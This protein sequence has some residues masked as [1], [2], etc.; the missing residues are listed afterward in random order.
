MHAC[1]LLCVCV[2]PIY[3]TNTH[4]HTHIH[5]YAQTHTSTH[6]HT[7]TLHKITLKLLLCSPSSFRWRFWRVCVGVCQCV[8]VCVGV[9]VHERTGVGFGGG[10][11]RDH[12]C[13]SRTEFLSSFRWKY[14]SLPCEHLVRLTSASQSLWS[15]DSLLAEEAIASK[16]RF[17]DCSHSRSKGGVHFPFWGSPWRLTLGSPVAHVR[18]L[19]GQSIFALCHTFFCSRGKP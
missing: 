7:H 5:I 15:Y 11:A 3:A 2:L 13:S 9:C 6:A 19:Q 10:E 16:I 14:L 17:F 4:T 8:S 18:S 12:G 1:T